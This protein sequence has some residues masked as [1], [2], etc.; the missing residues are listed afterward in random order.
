MIFV[1]VGT[2]QYPFNRLLDWIDGA[3]CKGG[4]TEEIVVQHG[5]CTNRVRG[6]TSDETLTQKAFNDRV[7]RA[8]LI[9]S[10]CGEGSFLQLRNRNKPFML[11]PRRTGLG[12]HL[13]DH[14]W[15]LAR[16]LKKIGVPVG[17]IPRDVGQFIAEPVAYRARL[18]F[19]SLVDH[20]IDHYDGTASFPPSAPSRRSIHTQVR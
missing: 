8:R 4:I 9:I 12:E 16:V 17:F 6:A 14:Q 20:L 19:P 1:T 7:D 13:D 15:E 11:V 3:V 2:E 18:S 5:A 10:H